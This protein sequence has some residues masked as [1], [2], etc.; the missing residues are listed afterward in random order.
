M[1]AFRT[2]AATAVVAMM[3]AIPAHA[4]QARTGPATQVPGAATQQ[5]QMSDAMVHKVGKALR[6]V[7]SIRQQY[8]QR[9][10]SVA[11][12]QQQ[13]TLTDQA[14]KDMEK[15]INDEGLSVQQYDQAIQMAQADPTL[16]HRLV[17]AAQSSD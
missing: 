4:Q 3:L 6:H 11:S 16:R 7:A 1:I 12:P 13:Q 17:S 15:A 14:E 9:A 8:A 2:A 10:Q 5:G